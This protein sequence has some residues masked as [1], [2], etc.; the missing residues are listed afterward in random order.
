MK[1]NTLD[2]HSIIDSGLSP[3]GG[4]CFNLERLLP[5]GRVNYFLTCLGGVIAGKTT[6]AAMVMEGLRQV[7]RTTID[8][9]DADGNIRN[10]NIGA[11][12]HKRE[13]DLPI[14]LMDHTVVVYPQVTQQTCGGELRSVTMQNTILVY[15]GKMTASGTMGRGDGSGT[16]ESTDFPMVLKFTENYYPDGFNEFADCPACD[17]IGSRDCVKKLQTQLDKTT[18]QYMWHRVQAQRP[19]N[20]NGQLDEF[21]STTHSTAIQVN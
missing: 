21:K 9:K 5:D 20:F 14:P 18:K 6:N 4:A 3:Q 17:D 7:G 1:E 2:F 19:S 8:W 13:Y 10:G 15:G 16:S 11:W 12:Q